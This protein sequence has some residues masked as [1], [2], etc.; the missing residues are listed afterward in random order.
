[1]D[2]TKPH[3]LTGAM[4]PQILGHE[5]SGTVVELGPGVESVSVGDRAAVY[6]LYSC[7]ACDACDAG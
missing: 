7:G 3:P 4:P 5:F 2:L 6:P 1:M